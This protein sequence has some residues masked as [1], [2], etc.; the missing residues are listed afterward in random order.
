[1]L[2]NA[3]CCVDTYRRKQPGCPPSLRALGFSFMFAL[4]KL[5]GQKSVSRRSMSQKQWDFNRLF[6]TAILYFFNLFNR[7]DIK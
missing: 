4:A 3:G 1:M 6:S 7:L 2:R 5:Q